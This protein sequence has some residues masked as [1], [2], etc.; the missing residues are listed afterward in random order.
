MRL[1]ELLFISPFHLFDSQEGS[2]LS[3]IPLPAKATKFFGES[4]ILR[5]IYFVNEKTSHRVEGG[6]RAYT[7]TIEQN[8]A[9]PKWSATFQPLGTHVSDI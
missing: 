6:R 2:S 7:Y 9:N 4:P 3:L 8:Q 5:W 1:D